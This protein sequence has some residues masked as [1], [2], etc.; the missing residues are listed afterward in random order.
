[1][2]DVLSAV[3]AWVWAAASLGSLAMAA[4]GVAGLPRVVARLPVDWFVRPAVPFAAALRAHPARVVGRNLVGLLLVL[5]G[6]ALLFL[7]GQGVLTIL[8]GL[9]F[10]DLPV[11]G[12]ALRWLGRRPALSRGLQRLRAWADAPPFAGLDQ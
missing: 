1:M 6:V 3:P 9:F 10:T 12:R 11:K 7:P 2:L 8:V 5:L 4:L